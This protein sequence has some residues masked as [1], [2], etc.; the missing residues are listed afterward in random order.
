MWGPFSSTSTP[1]TSCRTRCPLHCLPGKGSPCRE[2]PCSPAGA[3]EPP[4]LLE[5]LLCGDMLQ[6]RREGEGREGSWGL[7]KRPGWAGH[8]HSHF[9]VVR[10]PVVL[11]VKQ[12]KVV[13]P[14]G[15]EPVDRRGRAGSPHA[16][17][18]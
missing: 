1:C 8:T 5:T 3:S 14:G 18:P 7:W 6:S 13:P 17:A 16:Q 11:L 10:S 4:D 12:F 15:H 2:A 9:H